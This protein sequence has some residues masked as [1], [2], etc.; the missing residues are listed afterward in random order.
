MPTDLNSILQI[1]LQMP[2]IRQ[3][4][5]S[6]LQGALGSPGLGLNY[7]GYDPTKTVEY[8]IA[9]A[10]RTNV[11]YDYLSEGRAEA[12]KQISQNAT[13]NMLRF[14][15]YDAE[16]AKKEASNPNQLTSFL[17]K[18]LIEPR[19]R[20]AASSMTSAIYGRSA[21][22]DPNAVG[23]T[24][25]AEAQAAY[26]GTANE[27][28][29]STLIAAANKQFGGMGIEDVGKLAGAYIQVGGFDAVSG[30]KSKEGKTQRINEINNEL[31]KYA[32][33]VNMLRDVIDGPVE[34]ILS[35]FE[36]LTGSKLVATATG[37][38]SDIASAMR[39]VLMDGRIDE[40]GLANMVATQYGLIAPMGGSLMQATA[41]ATASAAAMNYGVK[42]EG[43]NDIEFGN[44][45]AQDNARMMANGSL[46]SMAAAY[47][48]WRQTNKKE[49]NADT[50]AEFMRAM[51]KEYGSKG[52]IAEQAQAYLAAQKDID[53]TFMGSAAV[54]QAMADTTLT[55]AAR[56]Q[57]SQRFDKAK[58]RILK[59]FGIDT[60]DEK[61]KAIL[62]G[63]YDISNIQERLSQ[64]V[65]VNK[66]SQIGMALGSAAMEITG[67]STWQTAMA[68]IGSAQGAYN[69]IQQNLA[70]D[71]FRRIRGQVRAG[72]ME[73][74]VD[75]FM[76]GNKTSAMSIS[77]IVKA[78]LGL[79][80]FEVGDSKEDREQM[81]NKMADK[82]ELGKGGAERLKNLFNAAGKLGAAGEAILFAQ[83]PGLS[84]KKLLE[85]REKLMETAQKEGVTYDELKKASKGM[86][87]GSATLDRIYLQASGKKGVEYSDEEVA[88]FAKYRAQYEADGVE[89]AAGTAAKRI[90]AAKQADVVRAQ[91]RQKGEKV[92][93]ENVAKAL[94]ETQEFKDYAEKMGKTDEKGRLELAQELS[95]RD[96]LMGILQDI[97]DALLNLGGQK[98]GKTNN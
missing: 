40:R 65:G 12:Y 66:A 63:N 96:G 94:A 21:Q 81:F 92:T 15:G 74:V 58:E 44:A 53:A 95:A 42:I 19:V 6:L 51:S 89:D 37:R 23:H 85:A 4:V 55:A 88:A 73:G 57:Y 86:L 46:R 61:F 97:L 38:V 22:W 32:E 64:L 79:D 76:Q 90:R 35:S 25:N 39:N 41:M 52:G 69:T 47:V 5:E 50:K 17:T 91:L 26:L 3:Q 10:R 30:I 84:G 48:H 54:T 24:V 83:A 27:W 70:G 9:N 93:R 43:L 18:T 45:L 20:A 14:M 62:D 28:I 1:L 98:P 75:A 13:E 82:M 33:S 60:N 87:I 49:D 78:A 2:G 77:N 68:T 36:K 31:Q 67:A 72:G 71:A 7:L 80:N 34:K 59:R 29:S 56:T 11:I 16:Q 8:N